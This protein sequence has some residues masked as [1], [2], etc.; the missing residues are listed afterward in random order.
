VDGK[1][2]P[3]KPAI[4]LPDALRLSTRHLSLLA[5][6]AT[7]VAGGFWGEYVSGLLIQGFLFGILAISVD[8]LWGVTGILTLGASA[9]FG[10]GAYA[11]G[12][13]FVHV[14]RDWWAIP[15]GLIVG[16][17]VA[18]LLSLLIGWLA[19]Y[20][21]TKVSEFYITIVTL[22]MS[23]LFA[24]I[25]NYGGR[26]TGGSSGLSGFTPLPAH[27]GG[28]YWL[29]AA[30]L[31]AVG[32]VASVIS[33]SDFGLVLRAIRDHETRCRYLGI[34]TPLVKTLMFAGCNAVAAVAGSLYALYSTVVAP[35]LVDFVLAT[36]TLIWVAL[37]GRGTLFGPAFAAIAINAGSP[38]LNAAIPFYWQG[39][40][41]LIF[42][43]SVV[44][45]PRGFLPAVGDWVSTLVRRRPHA[46][47]A[48]M[49]GADV[50]A[51]MLAVR[52]DL[53]VPPLSIS[54]GSDRGMA[55]TPSHAPHGPSATLELRRVEK[56]YG[57]F[58]ALHDVTLSVTR[59]ELV[60]IVG[61]NGA[62]KTSLLRCLSDG[63]E[64][65]AG[66]VLVSGMSIGTLPPDKIVSLGI[67][68]KFQG[69]SVF[70]ELTVRECMMIASWRGRLPSLWR[71]TSAVT[72][73]PPAA[74]VLRRLRL[75]DVWQE[76]AA[77]I[78]HGQRQ[79]LELA[80]VLALEPT[81]LLLDE[82][83]AGLTE[84]E[85]AGVGTALRQLVRDHRLSIVL[86]EHDFEFVK[87][88]STRMVVLHA[89]QVLIDGSVSEVAASQ[90]VRDVYLGRQARPA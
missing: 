22:G 11:M 54:R 52:P 47:L 81:F 49:L 71:R 36:N 34:D 61:P 90:L 67:A 20:S 42:V 12:I 21:K 70:G 65:T 76:R 45:L 55:G 51:Q 27:N 17:L 15:A 50:A 85:R 5:L 80:M 6:L 56:W 19:F 13:C 66:D 4:R 25:A 29:T 69:A 40:L 9:M 63:V 82:P 58:P 68:R 43:V 39:F 84:D 53:H 26:L 31:A 87:E 72:V 64:R 41:G 59:G 73:P 2:H 3:F 75:E 60:S 33:R 35:S 57:S 37:G 32:A 86:I 89:G 38:S 23:V 78:S 62:G 1:P 74:S 16:V 46:T 14:T 44:S 24:Q 30:V 77:N 83:T 88:I 10:I 18:F 48:P 28:W 8:M 7:L 79:T